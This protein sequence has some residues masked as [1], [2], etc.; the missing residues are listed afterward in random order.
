MKEFIRRMLRSMVTVALR[1][2]SH[3]LQLTPDARCLIIAPHQ[4]D[5]AFGCAGLILAQRT[6][7]IPVDIVYLTDGSGSHPGHPRLAPAD[8]ARIRHQEAVNAMQHLCIPSTSLH[9]ID[10]SDGMLDRLTPAATAEFT[11]RLGDLIGSLRPTEIFL[12]CEED[13]SSEHTAAFA[14]SRQALRLSGLQPRMLEYPVWA[15]WRP[16]QLLRLSRK[17]RHVWRLTFPN[18]AL[19]KSAILD[20]YVSQTDPTPPWTDPVLPQGFVGCFKSN[21]EFFFER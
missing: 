14:L 21:E 20:M 7:G 15:R 12:P 13:S 9:F 10:A 4:D 6:L 3:P 17:N 8:I 2:R 11:R 18:A 5:E 16:Q 1:R 19:L